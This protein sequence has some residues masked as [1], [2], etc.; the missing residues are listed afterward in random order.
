MKLEPAN[1]KCPN[2]GNDNYMRHLIGKNVGRLDMKCINCNSY[3]SFDELYKK[4]IS[5][6]IKLKMTNADRIRAMT[7]EELADN[8]AR[9]LRCTECP[10]WDECHK[11]PDDGRECRDMLLG[12]LRQEVEQ[13]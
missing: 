7:D 13:C 4:R 3:F 10:V 11:T 2:C 8:G 1:I 6:A 5:E 12:W 9:M